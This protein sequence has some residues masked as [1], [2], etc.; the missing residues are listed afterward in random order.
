MGSNRKKSNIAFLRVT[1]IISQ[2]DGSNNIF[3][4]YIFLFRTAPS[5]PVRKN[6]G[7]HEGILGR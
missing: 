6:K 2:L 5:K 7:K 4:D 3:D 1:N